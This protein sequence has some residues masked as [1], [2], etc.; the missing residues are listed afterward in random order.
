MDHR[1]ETIDRLAELDDPAFFALAAHRIALHRAVEDT[2]RRRPVID[3][4]RLAEH[5][6]CR[7]LWEVAVRL[8]RQ[9][10]ARA[11]SR[12]EAVANGSALP[13]PAND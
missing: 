12:E 11:A 8:R 2:E 1:L 10:A 13:P 7:Q 4:E 6:E 5:R 9:S 3:L